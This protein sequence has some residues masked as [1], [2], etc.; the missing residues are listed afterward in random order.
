M[1]C[2]KIL[3]PS[4]AVTKLFIV[5]MA[6]FVLATAS[7]T[8]REKLLAIEFADDDQIGFDQWPCG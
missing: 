1:K 4:I 8:A 5:A 6:V 3:R 7:A 2:G